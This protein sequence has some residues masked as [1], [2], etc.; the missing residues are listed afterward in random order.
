M[1]G[2]ESE[3]AGQQPA[4]RFGLRILLL[5]D[6]LLPAARDGRCR[7]PRFAGEHDQFPDRAPGGDTRHG[8]RT[9]PG[10]IVGQLRDRQTPAEG[11]RRP[12]LGAAG[13]H[14]SE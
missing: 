9:V 13:F 11:R 8:F 4:H 5:L 14:A 3:H 10:T 1:E 6:A 2:G 7:Q 12:Q